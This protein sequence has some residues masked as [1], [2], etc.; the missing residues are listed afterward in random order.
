MHPE[1]AGI[2]LEHRKPWVAALL[3][4]AL[5]GL[6]QVYNGEPG[7]GLAAYLSLP[8]LASL[9]GFFVLGTF[10]GLVIFLVLAVLLYLGIA[11]DAALR[12]RHVQAIPLRW[13][14]RPAIYFV[15]AIVVPILAAQ[16]LARAIFP[17]LRFRTYKIPAASMEPTLQIGDHLV[18]DMW[19]YRNRLPERGDVIVFRAPEDPRLD[20]VKRCVAVQGDTLEIHDKKLS[21]NGR[22]LSEPYA[23]HSDPRIFQDQ[24]SPQAFQRDQTASTKV[25]PSSCYFLGDNRDASYDSRFWGTAPAGLLRGKALYIYW[26]PDRSRIGMRIR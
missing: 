10:S 4:L 25:P 6:G 16:I 7:R 21:L 17:Q 19:V 3:S 9:A 23:I 24:L 18:A 14:N 11:A 12:S 20:L 13:Y 22:Q 15:L 1:G 5:P 2:P 8:V 26:S